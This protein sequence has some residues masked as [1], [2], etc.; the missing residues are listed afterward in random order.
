MI[1]DLFGCLVFWRTIYMAFCKIDTSLTNSVY[2]F[3]CADQ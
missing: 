3:D 1:S 2:T